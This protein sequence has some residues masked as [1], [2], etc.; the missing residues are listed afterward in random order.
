MPGICKAGALLL[1]GK[2]AI[3]WSDGGGGEGGPG[4]GGG[5]GPGPGK[6]SFP[7]S[8]EGP[9]GGGGGSSRG[10]MNC[11][12]C[13][14]EVCPMIICGVSDSVTGSCGASI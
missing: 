13:C 7:S 9:G 11:S 10:G 1:A 14:E 12:I 8:S 6:G 4:G 3:S 5:G 2:S